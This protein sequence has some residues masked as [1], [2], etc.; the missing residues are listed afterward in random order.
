MFKNSNAYYKA[1]IEGGICLCLAGHVSR[2]WNRL[3]PSLLRIYEKLDKLGLK[4]V[5]GQVVY[6]ERG[7]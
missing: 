4:Y 2:R 5:D 7:P 6:Q 1:S 3:Y